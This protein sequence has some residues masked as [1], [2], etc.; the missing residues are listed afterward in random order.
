MSRYRILKVT[1]HPYW[2]N[3]VEYIVQKRVWGFLWWW[4]VDDEY[5]YGYY[6]KLEE[7]EQRL[8]AEMAADKYE[9]VRE[10]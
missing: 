1:R 3:N 4:P 7:A 8:K 10:Y 9:V 5:P 6:D 2:R